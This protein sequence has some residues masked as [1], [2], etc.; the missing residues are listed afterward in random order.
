MADADRRVEHVPGRRRGCGDDLAGA[1]GG[2]GAGAGPSPRPRRR[3]G[4]GAGAVRA[5][6]RGDRRL[7]YSGQFLSKDRTARALAELFGTPV[8]AG[9]VAAM[10][11]RAAA[12]LTCFTGRAR[13]VLRNAQVAHFDETSLRVAS[14]LRWVHS[15][16]TGK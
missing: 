3:R 12:G 15:A 16:P 8:S 10:T 11:A 6:R 4:G 2:A 14:K 7:L 13:Q 9:T 1:P 5:E